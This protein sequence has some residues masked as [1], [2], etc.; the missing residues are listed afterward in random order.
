[1]AT[2]PYASINFNFFGFFITFHDR[3]GKIR[4]YAVHIHSYRIHYRPV[5]S[6]RNSVFAFFSFR[7][8]SFVRSFQ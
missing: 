3:N 2:S 7:S 8:S 6:S 5:Q 1:M 4:I